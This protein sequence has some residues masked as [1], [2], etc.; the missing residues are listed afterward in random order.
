MEYSRIDTTVKHYIKSRNE[1]RIKVENAGSEEDIIHG[2]VVQFGIL[3]A[4]V[5]QTGFIN[6]DV[7]NGVLKK[8]LETL[9]L[10]NVEKCD[11]SRLSLVIKDF[12]TKHWYEI[13]PDVDGG[14]CGG[15]Y[16][17]S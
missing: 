10:P 2:V 6:E 12:I 5:E 4:F 17:L 13:E 15:G 8:V 7:F 14:S 16:V 9:A 3:F 11:V 1:V